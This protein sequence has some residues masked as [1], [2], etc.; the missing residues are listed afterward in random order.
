MRWY[1]SAPLTTTERRRATAK[2][3]PCARNHRPPL[4]ILSILSLLSTLLPLSALPA[5]SVPLIL[6]SVT[7][8]AIEPNLPAPRAAGRRQ[9]VIA[10]AH[11]AVAVA[12]GEVD[13]D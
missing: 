10:V 2:P 5:L 13:H 4:S 8:S 9:R 11:L 6:P 1:P 7:R 12:V 3:G